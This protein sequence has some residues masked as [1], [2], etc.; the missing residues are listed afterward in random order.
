MIERTLIVI[1][2]AA[3]LGVG[4]AVLRRVQVWRAARQAPAD[5]LLAAFQ[6]GIPGVVYFTSP[7]CAPCQF[8]QKPAL[9][10]L[11]ADLGDGIQVIEVDALADAAAAS[12]WGVLSVPTTFIL[13]GQ[14]QPRD[15]N[16][17]VAGTAKLKAQVQ[18]I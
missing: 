11:Q 15:V 13:D 9:Q 2:L 16:H 1:G 7:Q 4:Y 14:G 12:R 18:R 6:P 10:G 17:G 5:P 8:Q 3:V